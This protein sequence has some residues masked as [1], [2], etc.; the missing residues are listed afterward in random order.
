MPFSTNPNSCVALR[1]QEHWWWGNRDSTRDLASDQSIASG[2]HDLQAAKRSEE[3]SATHRKKVAAETVF[4]WRALQFERACNRSSVVWF[5]RGLNASQKR[6]VARIIGSAGARRGTH[7]PHR[8][9]GW[10]KDATRSR[11]LTKSINATAGS[12]GHCAGGTSSRNVS[13]PGS[14]STKQTSCRTEWQ[15]LSFERLATIQKQN[16]TEHNTPAHILVCE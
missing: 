10:L 13:S 2:W 8:I 11:L 6:N 5:C 7:R 15:L 12:V 3:W 9:G 16:V 14:L 4:D 1:W